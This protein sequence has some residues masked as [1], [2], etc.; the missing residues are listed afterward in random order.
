VLRVKLVLE[1]MGR[2]R[3]LKTELVPRPREGENLIE[4]ADRRVQVALG[5][6]HN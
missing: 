3:I 5:C 6:L 2:V 1:R 4:P